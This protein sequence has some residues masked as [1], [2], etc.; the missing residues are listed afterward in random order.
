LGAVFRC[1][2]VFGPLA[3]LG[4]PSGLGAAST[5]Y[6]ITLLPSGFVELSDLPSFNTAKIRPSNKLISDAKRQKKI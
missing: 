2:S 6:G 3:C 4:V 5:V 1:S